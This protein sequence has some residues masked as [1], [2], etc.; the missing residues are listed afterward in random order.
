MTVLVAYGTV[1]GSTAEI[2][3]WIGAEL[4]T[5]GLD[6]SVRA[7]A[8]VDDV[9]RFE[10]LVLGGAVYATGWHVDARQFAQHFGPAFEG[11]PVWIFSSGPLDHVTD[12]TDPPPGPQ[13]RTA[14]RALGAC[15]HVTFGGR[16][17][18]DARGWL[19]HVA[20]RIAGEGHSGDFR[21]PDR[22][23]AWARRVANEIKAARTRPQ[24]P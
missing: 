2:A 24:Q 15:E 14:M 12:D 23:R 6:V 21:D 7:V 4:A 16:L 18:E 8:D 20:R 1:S 5:A 22:V 13:V 10:A 9:A 3:Q 19:G 11:R 17:N